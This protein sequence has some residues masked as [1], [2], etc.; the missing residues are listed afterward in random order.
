MRDESRA[1][2]DDLIWEDWPVK[3]SAAH[4]CQTLGFSFPTMNP[5]VLLMPRRSL[6]TGP[7]PKN[8]GGEIPRCGVSPGRVQDPG[9]VGVRGDFPM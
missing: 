1:T 4:L 9:R 5:S 8:S 7:V 6:D 3:Q 2:K